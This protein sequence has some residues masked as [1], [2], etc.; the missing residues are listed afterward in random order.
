M[1]AATW[2]A[3]SWMP[4]LYLFLKANSA[5]G[6]VSN[7]HIFKA[8]KLR[9]KTFWQLAKSGQLIS[10]KSDSNQGGLA[11]STS[12]SPW[13]TPRSWGWK[14]H[15]TP[16]INS[17]ISVCVS[18]TL[19]HSP[20]HVNHLRFL[21][22]AHLFRFLS[23]LLLSSCILLTSACCSSSYPLH[24]H[25]PILVPLSLLFFFPPYP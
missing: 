22:L 9:H 18:P 6:T 19:F 4:Y 3:L 11:P 24:F 25:L 1:G 13:V 5:V 23:L 8:G 20:T 17:T 10:R 15:P 7:T 2:T 21:T 12:F 16:Q 14:I